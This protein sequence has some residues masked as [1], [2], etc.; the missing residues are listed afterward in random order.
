MSS[1]DNLFKSFE[2]LVLTDMIRTEISCEGSYSNF[3]HRADRDLCWSPPLK[4]L[5]GAESKVFKVC[6]PL[7]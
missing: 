2:F 6:Q 5:L 1:A 7:Q 4:L 3:V